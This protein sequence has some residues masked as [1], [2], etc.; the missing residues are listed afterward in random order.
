M[1]ITGFTTTRPEMASTR[2]YE[3]FSK[4]LGHNPA[5]LGI[6]SSLYDQYT[7]SYLTEALMNIYVRDR[8]NKDAFTSINEFMVEWDINVNFIKRVPFLVKPTGDGAQGTDIIFH[9]P[10]N[11]YQ[12]NDVFVIE[13]SR[14]QVIVLSRPIRRSDADWEVVGKI[15]DSDYSSVL[16]A[17]ACEPGMMT[18]FLT[19]YHPEFHREGL[20]RVIIVTK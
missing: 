12:K 5:R 10:E 7:A 2:T 6:V 13:E 9:F 16:D 18:R 17:S 8:K 3:D 14:Q 11:Y 4:F 15:Q 19:N 1:K 20:T